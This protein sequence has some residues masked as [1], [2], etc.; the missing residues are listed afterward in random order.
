MFFLD[1]LILIWDGRFT[2]G[3]SDIKWLI[4]RALLCVR[5]FVFFVDNLFDFFASVHDVSVLSEDRERQCKVYQLKIQAKAS[6]H[7]FF[8]VS[9]S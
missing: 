8:T 5:L 6:Q 1:C 9:A 3:L 2:L 7:L 4:T